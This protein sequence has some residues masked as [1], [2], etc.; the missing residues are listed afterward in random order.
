[1]VWS[2][3]NLPPMRHKAVGR[4]AGLRHTLSAP[5]GHTKPAEAR[6]GKCYFGTRLVPHADLTQTN[7]H[8]GEVG[9]TLRRTRERVVWW[10]MASVAFS[11]GLAR[12]LRSLFNGQIDQRMI[13]FRRNI[14]LT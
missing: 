1:M 10:G 3:V 4:S 13:L 14:A 11:V 6:D 7:T 8:F 9:S 5:Y 12:R 2:S